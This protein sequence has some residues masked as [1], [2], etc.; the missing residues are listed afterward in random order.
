[1]SVFLVFRS[2]DEAHKWS[3]W[4]ME[5]TVAVKNEYGYPKLSI[6]NLDAFLI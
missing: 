6:T 4:V 5:K 2:W 1:V 3:L